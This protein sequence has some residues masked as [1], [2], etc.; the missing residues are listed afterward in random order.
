[1]E[2]KDYYKVLGVDRKVSAEEI[3]KSYRKLA[4]KYHPDRN[5]DDRAAEEK[6][7]EINEAYQVLSDKEKRAR[8]DQLGSSYNSWQQTGAGGNFNWDDWFSGA[9]GGGVRVEMGGLGDMY[10]EFFN[11]IFGGMGGMGG[12]GTQSR[13]RT[14]NPRT[15]QQAYAQPQTY[16]QP[17]TISFY[18]A[19]HGAER[20]LQLDGQRVTAKIP[21]GAK[22]GT[23]VRI[24]GVGPAG[25]DGRKSNIHL[26]ITVAD[27][28]RFERK[29]DDL[30][31]DVKVDFYTAV[32]GGKVKIETPT[33]N[34]KLKIPAGTQP[35]QLFRLAGRG[36][37]KL[38]SP[39]S[40]GD[41]YARVKIE[42]PRTLSPEQRR[43]FE[44]LQNMG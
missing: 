42:T 28:A 40:F 19:Y 17:V 36:M 30:Y 15:R 23:K 39:K 35:D 7:K 9:P 5:P 2:Y 21:A 18:E 14:A 20:V 11:A 1:M 33:G 16:E 8:Y 22:T 24:S 10:S 27:D 44:Q 29:K 31:T 13:R 41:L 43:L 38:R 37:P 34:V 25:I 6:F 12:V 4:M 3:K 26:K 32:L